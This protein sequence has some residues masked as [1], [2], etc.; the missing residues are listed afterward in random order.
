MNDGPGKSRSSLR[1]FLA[2][3]NFRRALA[4]SAIVTALAIPRLSTAGYGLPLMLLYTLSAFISMTLVCGAVT[5]WTGQRGLSRMIPDRRPLLLGVIVALLVGLVFGMLKAL[6]LDPV[7]EKAMVLNLPADEVDLHF[8]VDGFGIFALVCWVAGFEAL[9]F[10]GG[11]MALWSRISGSAWLA[12]MVTVLFRAV[13]VLIQ[14][15][16]L[17][18][19]AWL[20]PTLFAYLVSQ[21]VGCQLF[22]RAG[23]IPVVVYNVVLQIGL[24]IDAA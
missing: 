19:G 13:V 17:D 18:L 4:L 15:N 14:M 10:E 23:L 1:E 6:I 9:F 7:L 12:T 3:E 5:A 21:T 20:V 22:A 16:R 8:P 11:T 2:V 24:L